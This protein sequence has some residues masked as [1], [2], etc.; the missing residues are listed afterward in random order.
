[1]FL[2]ICH[3]SELNQYLLSKGFKI[4]LDTASYL[5]SDYFKIELVSN[6]P[7]NELY[8]LNT[9]D[10]PSLNC[11]VFI[12]NYDDSIFAIIDHLDNDKSLY[13]YNHPFYLENFSESYNKFWQKT[14]RCYKTE[15]NINQLKILIRNLCKGEKLNEFNELHDDR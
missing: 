7:N 15:L 13:I 11:T 10:I 12:R 6:T 5:D 2:Q 3:D 4:N 9:I 14:K 8:I 1:M